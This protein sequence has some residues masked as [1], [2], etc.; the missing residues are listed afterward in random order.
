MDGSSPA[1]RPDRHPS[2]SYEDILDRDTR[3]VP[4][5]LRQGPTPDIG[6]EP[7]PVSRYFSPEYFAKEVEHVWSRVWQMACREEE[8]PNVG[9]YQ[10][11]EIVG[12][13]LIVARTAPGEIKAFY[14]S[15][16]HRGR[17]L[18]TLN[19]C[20]NE[21]R[22]PYH[23][24]TWN[25]DGSFKENPIGW[26]FP[27]W[28]GQ[29]MSL[30]QARVDTWGGFVF[31]NMDANAAPLMDFIGPLAEH[32]ADYEYENRYKAVHVAKVVRCNW[33]ALAEA[34][35]ESHHSVTT[36]PQILPFLADAN[37]QY[38]IF[39][40]YVSRQFSASGV[41]SPFVADQNYTA[42]Q[43]V[44]AMGGQGNGTRR[45]GFGE[46]ETQV[47]DGITA[48]A[49][50]ADQARVSLSAE[51]GWDYSK[52]SDAEMVDA[53]L[54]N[55]WPNMSFWAGYAPNLVYRWRPNGRDPESGIMDVIIL[56]RVPK[57]GPRPKPASVHE[58]DVDE[59][60]SSAV[61]LG[62]LAGIFEQDMGNLP[63]VQEGLHASGTGVVHFGRYSELRI[64]KLHQMVEQ[65]I[66]E[67]E[68]ARGR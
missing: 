14:N 59:P 33:K 43:I 19:G 21:F 57:D 40:D 64:R 46:G 50:A 27:Q 53:L 63:Y 54:Y 42:T 60:W 36:H 55:V 56:K 66:A 35:M 68:A 58:L 1:Y 5:F 26:D 48:R 15:C 2:E 45:R 29:D 7:V 34:F 23:G 16:L 4:A 6:L 39:N 51:D 49:Y 12:K 22:C 31:V 52:A 24:F 47:P 8:I 65:Y 67:G 37:S 61:E 11:Y 20:K 30:P 18:V 13:S 3:P 28:E 62:G 17:K 38:D 41:P 9:D 25:A 10:I 32:F 44:Q